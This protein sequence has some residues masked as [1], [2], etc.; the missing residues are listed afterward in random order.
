MKLPL[1][2]RGND[3]L[4]PHL[5]D[6]LGRAFHLDDPDP[7]TLHRL[8][9]R[10]SA[11]LEAPPSPA[12]L[13]G[14]GRGMAAARRAAVVGGVSA[15]VLLGGVAA[16]QTPAG[17]AVLDSITSAVTQTVDSVVHLVAPGLGRSATPKSAATPAGDLPGNLV[18]Q[19]HADGSFS[20]RAEL[21][22]ATATTAT[23][24]AA[25]VGQ[26]TFDITHTDIQIPKGLGIDSL[27]GAAGSLVFLRGKCTGD[28]IDATCTVE[29]L[30]VVGN[31]GQGGNPNPGGNPNSGG[32]NPNSGGGNPNAGGGKPEGTP[33]P[34]KGQPTAPPTTPALSPTATQV[35][36]GLD[37]TSTP[38]RGP[39]R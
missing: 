35:P 34:G 14:I 7:Q 19:L 5:A 38:P 32:G 29:R 31:A 18:T 12:E 1:F 17:S 20:L 16:A 36:P 26:L 37:R 4:D 39:Q 15:A 28:H 3:E 33:A 11:R 25:D 24:R 13:S 21:V 30:N 22:S 6:V 9:S 23:V 27:P 8:R 2:R 10:V